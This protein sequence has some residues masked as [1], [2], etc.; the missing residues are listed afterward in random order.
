MLVGKKFFLNFLPGI[1][2]IWAYIRFRIMTFSLA[3]HTIFISFNTIVNFIIT[4]IV[5]FIV[6]IL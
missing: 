6:I 3:F 4:V 1:V 2:R 5:I